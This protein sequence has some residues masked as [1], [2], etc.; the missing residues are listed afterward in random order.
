MSDKVGVLRLPV[1]SDQA[2]ATSGPRQLLWGVR[3]DKPGRSTTIPSQSH[4]LL[5]IPYYLHHIARARRRSFCLLPLFCFS[6]VQILRVVPV[7]DKILPPIRARW[8]RR[9]H[10]IDGRL[11]LSA[12]AASYRNE[13]L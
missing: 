13:M 10:V 6:S 2:W 11:R 9:A 3:P 8:G 5:T 12:S 4:L 1:L 7:A